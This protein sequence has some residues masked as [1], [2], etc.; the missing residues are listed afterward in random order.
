MNGVAE[1]VV[2][3]DAGN[4][5]TGPDR[6]KVLKL[7]AG[8]LWLGVHLRGQLNRYLART[9]CD[10]R[11]RL[12]ELGQVAGLVRLADIW[13]DD[14]DTRRPTQVRAEVPVVAEALPS[15]REGDGSFLQCRGRAPRLPSGS[16]AGITLRLRTLLMSWR[17]LSVRLV[18]LG[19]VT[20]V[21]TRRFAH[22]GVLSI[23]VLI[24]D[25]APVVQTG[26]L[27][28]LHRG[29]HLPAPTGVVAET[30]WGH[31][32]VDAQELVLDP[33]AA[34]DGDSQ[35][36][37]DLVGISRPGGVDEL[38]QPREG[39]V[40]AVPV[41]GGDV[42]GEVDVLLVAVGVVEVALG[43][44]DLSQ[45][46]DNESVAAGEHLAADLL[47]LPARDV[48]V[49]AVKEGGVVVLLGKLVEEVRVLEHVGNSVGRVADEDHG[50]LR[51]EGLDAPGEGL[52]GHIV[53][54]DVDERPVGPLLLAGELV[55]GDAVPVSDQPDP[56]VG[57]VD[58]ELGHR[59]LSA[60]DQ[61]PVRGELGVDVGLARP[62]G[63][64]LDEVVVALHEGNEPHQVE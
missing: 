50:G 40:D 46:V 61:H 37:L 24:R 15:I 47:E 31:G 64:K 63:A 4:G 6:L 36:G 1:G 53:L 25:G 22:T 48:A 60:G 44:E 30:H 21:G 27:V 58:E 28:L 34:L 38:H 42:L 23:L 55:E 57:V 35:E 12:D 8:A 16:R 19:R 32:P 3:G 54:H 20:G 10:L 5:S 43:L 52:V 49:D 7:L 2:E 62:L 45:V 14:V 56:P 39:L 29:D 9:I 13:V 51:P 33:F 26:V 17:G 11:D 59:H 41:A 18:T